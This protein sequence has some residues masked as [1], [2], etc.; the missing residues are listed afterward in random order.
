MHMASHLLLRERG[1][2]LPAQPRGRPERQG[3]H[4][5]VQRAGGRAPSSQPLL[6]MQILGLPHTWLASL[7]QGT[8]TQPPVEVLLPHPSPWA[9]QRLRAAELSLEPALLDRRV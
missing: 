8:G 4:G 9:L 3:T 6:A 1:H 7:L 2:R 5:A